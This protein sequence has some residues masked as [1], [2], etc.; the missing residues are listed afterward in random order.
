MS[1]AAPLVM[2]ARR[3]LPLGG[4]TLELM[5]SDCGARSWALR[6]APVPGIGARPQLLT[7]GFCD[8]AGERNA[9]AGQLRAIA[10]AVEDW[11]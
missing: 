5:R 1:G 6:S 10:D 7:N 9:L 8:N 11:P 4:L 2:L 3:A